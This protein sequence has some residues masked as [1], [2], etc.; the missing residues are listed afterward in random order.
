MKYMF[1]GCSNLTSL[2]LTSFSFQND[3]A[4]TSMF[5]NVGKEATNKPIS[6][7]MTPAGKAYIESKGDSSINSSYA[8]II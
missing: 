6:I 2:N 4:I 3:V 5:Y 8:K 1:F 7:D